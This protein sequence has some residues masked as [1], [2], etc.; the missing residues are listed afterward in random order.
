M[1]EEL[2][3]KR[4]WL[5]AVWPGMGNVALAAGYYLMAKL[6]MGLFGEWSSRELFDVEQVEVKDGIIQPGRLPRSRLFV[7]HSDHAAHDIVL[8]IGEA[9]P[10]I[11]KYTFCQ[12]LIEFTKKFNVER[13]VTFAAMAT[14]MQPTDESRVF[15]AASNGLILNELGPYE[16]TV[17]K[18]GH[19][20][21]LNGVL[22]GAAIDAGLPGICLLGE[23]PHILAQLPYPKASL[24]VLDKFATIAGIKLDLSELHDEAAAFNKHLERL[25]AQ[26]E[27][28]M[29]GA[30]Q[31]EEEPT[32]PEPISEGALPDEDER[33]VEQLF[34]QAQIDRSKAYELKRELDRL[35]VFKEYENR[36][37]DL[38]RKPE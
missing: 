15:A 12:Q 36:F 31:A 32:F 18:E 25:M 13:V 5:V 11:G 4:P 9:Q 30:A 3:L 22:L 38:F 21:G 19:I 6:G 2:D 29:R 17:L 27:E 8:F 26:L 16:L 35:G 1:A 24:A 14:Q 33:H 10:P 20:G 23:M 7:S 37:L 28:Q 34:E